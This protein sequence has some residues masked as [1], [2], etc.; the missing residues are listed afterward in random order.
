MTNKEIV[1]T[2][3]DYEFDAIVEL[4]EVELAEKG[5]AAEALYADIPDTERPYDLNLSVDLSAN[6]KVGLPNNKPNL[7][8]LILDA[9]SI[10]D[11]LLL[12][13]NVYAG[14]D[15]A[16]FSEALTFE[17]NRKLLSQITSIQVIK[18][19]VEKPLLDSFNSQDR[20]DKEIAKAFLDTK[21]YTDR[22]SFGVNKALQST[23]QFSE[24]K[25]FVVQKSL[26]SNLD[27]SDD[28]FGEATLDDDQTISF[29]KVIQT[30][31]DVYDV[32]SRVVDY[33]R[34]VSSQFTKSEIISKQFSKAL[35]SNIGS[36]DNSV[37]VFGKALTSN[38]DPT[39]SKQL[40]VAKVLSDSFAKSDSV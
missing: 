40:I 27:I 21:T 12:E 2:A 32:F 20:V 1:V 38:I 23:S 36:T 6:L 25:S 8:K 24:V 5:I 9:F 22:I 13:R 7:F 16:K 19:G 33:K 30:S 29:L 10:E 31:S 34:V 28:I 15:P 35:R 3:E 39:D 18:L 26:R 14:A 17:L 37:K 11:F 4:K